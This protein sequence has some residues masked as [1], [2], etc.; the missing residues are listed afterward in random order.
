MG[1][2]SHSEIGVVKKK[3]WKQRNRRAT[4]INPI[5]GVYRVGFQHPAAWGATVQRCKTFWTNT[6]ENSALLVGFV[7]AIEFIR[8]GQ[9]NSRKKRF[10]L[11]EKPDAS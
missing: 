1:I 9:V 11:G 2:P 5:A 3:H 7:Q 4:G 8:A 6:S 10:K